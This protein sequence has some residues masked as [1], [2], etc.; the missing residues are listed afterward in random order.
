M[1]EIKKCPKCGEVM[2]KGQEGTHLWKRF[3]KKTFLGAQKYATFACLKCGL[4]ESYLE[5]K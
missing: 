4:L 1:E 3:E 2:V 5:L